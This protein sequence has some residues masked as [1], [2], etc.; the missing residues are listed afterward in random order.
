MVRRSVADHSYGR[1]TIAWSVEFREVNAL[2]RAEHELAVAYRERD[3]ASHEHRFDVRGRISLGVAELLVPWN[4]LVEEIE[5]IALHLGVG[6]L[7]DEHAGGRVGDGDGADAVSD[8]RTGDRGAHAS[9]DVDRRLARL[10]L[11]PEV[12]VVDHG[13][14]ILRACRRGAKHAS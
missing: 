13:P 7:V 1:A 9:R 2:P 10:R 4:D 12:L 3:V 6:V 8:L 5:Q 11:D 14:T